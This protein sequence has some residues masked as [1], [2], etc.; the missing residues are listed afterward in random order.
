MFIFFFV[1]PCPSHISASPPLTNL[2]THIESM[3]NT[4]HPN[5]SVRGHHK[6]ADTLAG[7]NPVI[8][9]FYGCYPF[10]AYC[11]VGTE[12][13]YV[14][15]FVLYHQPEASLAL[16]WGGFGFSV[17]IEMVCYWWCLPA[18]LCKQ[19]VNIAQLCAAAHSLASLGVESQDGDSRGAIE[20]KAK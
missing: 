3:A 13:L 6:A 8:R 17:S 16:G 11:C 19:V 10:F 7:R 1:C 2:L 15:L 9:L 20:G 12:M 18:C 4:P 14:L 5:P